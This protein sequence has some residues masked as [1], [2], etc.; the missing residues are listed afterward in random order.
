MRPND[1]TS[2]LNE[3]DTIHQITLNKG[4]TKPI[5]ITATVRKLVRKPRFELELDF[6]NEPEH[7]P[8]RHKQDSFSHGLLTK[9]EDK[10][11]ITPEDTTF[12]A[13]PTPAFRQKNCDCGHFPSPSHRDSNKDKNCNTW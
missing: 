1:A 11:V 8:D 10:K 5:T 7:G 2:P 12:E 3:G 13:G 4:S 9:D 6:N